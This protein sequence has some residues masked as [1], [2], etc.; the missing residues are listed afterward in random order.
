MK[1]QPLLGNKAEN[2]NKVPL[3]AVVPRAA[4]M[5]SQWI[6]V[7]QMPVVSVGTVSEGGAAGHEPLNAPTIKTGRCVHV[8]SPPAARADE[9][10]WGSDQLQR[11][12][13]S[14]GVRGTPGEV[15]IRSEPAA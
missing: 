10:A 14:V 15:C 2:V 4:L 9:A 7:Q 6:N 12:V 11:P 13:G 5:S 8:T 3:T 1:R